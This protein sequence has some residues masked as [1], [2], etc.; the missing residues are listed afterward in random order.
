[1]NSK[2][3]KLKEKLNSLS[4]EKGK[5]GQVFT[6]QDWD[7]V[8]SWGEGFRQPKQLWTEKQIE[9]YEKEIAKKIDI[10]L[11]LVNLT[12]GDDSLPEPVLYEPSPIQ[13][14]VYDRKWR[15]IANVSEFQK[16]AEQL[17]KEYGFV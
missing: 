1:M 7:E 15:P 14:Y 16:V 17:N 2:I 10:D 5:Y 8:K 4:P 9:N 6:S 12:G 13:V 3:N 11:Q